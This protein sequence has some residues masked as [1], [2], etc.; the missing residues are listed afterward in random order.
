VAALLLLLL[1][2]QL[3]TSCCSLLLRSATGPQGTRR[4]LTLRPRACPSVHHVRGGEGGHLLQW[5]PAPGNLVLPQIAGT[6]SAQ[7]QRTPAALALHRP[8]ACCQ[9]SPA[10][11]LLGIVSCHAPPAGCPFHPVLPNLRATAGCRGQQRAARAGPDSGARTAKAKRL[12]PGAVDTTLLLPP[13][14]HL[15]VV[16]AGSLCAHPLHTMQAAT[17]FLHLD[18]VHSCPKGRWRRR[19]QAHLHC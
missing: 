2:H 17:S 5:R 18:L 12:Q 14:G 9:Q 11:C 8:P 7:P 6:A 16:R 1:L 4:A 10:H 15:G 3:L 13:K 19:L